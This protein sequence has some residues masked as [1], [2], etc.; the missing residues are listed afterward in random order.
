MKRSTNAVVLGEV[1][2]VPS[3]FLLRG[4]CDQ[5]EQFRVNVPHGRC[6][7]KSL[8]VTGMISFLHT[9]MLLN[10]RLF[11]RAPVNSPVVFF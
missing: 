8:M 10:S 7:P 4:T 5:K 2:N 6:D 3:Q 11:S 1:L 9:D